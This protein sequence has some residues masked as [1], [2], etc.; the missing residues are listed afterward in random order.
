MIINHYHLYE[1]EALLFNLA[2]E[3]FSR[4]SINGY[5]EYSYDI[6]DACYTFMKGE[7][8]F[9]GGYE[10]PRAIAKFNMNAC[11]VKPGTGWDDVLPIGH[12]D[13]VY[14]SCANYNDVTYLCFDEDGVDAYGCSV[15]DGEDQKLLDAKSQHPHDWAA[16]TVYD[17]KMWVVGGCDPL[18]YDCNGIVEFFDGNSWNL[19]AHHPAEEI[20][21]HLLL[22]DANALYTIAGRRMSQDVYMFKDNT[23]TLIGQLTENAAD[24]WWISSGKIIGDYAYL[25]EE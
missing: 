16:M 4:A 13:G 8:Y 22:A 10:N 21:G 17:D 7:H 6:E 25:G 23:W 14:G 5:I 20:S 9:L 18:T 1:N 19:A 24:S 2:T 12:M 11:E 3:Q 15:F